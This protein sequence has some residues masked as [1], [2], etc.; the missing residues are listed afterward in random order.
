[1]ANSKTNSLIKEEKQKGITVKQYTSG[2][3]K[4]IL[5]HVE[6]G[7]SRFRLTI[8]MSLLYLKKQIN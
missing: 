3:L 8:N 6:K 5:F 7:K 2:S 1:M 4:G